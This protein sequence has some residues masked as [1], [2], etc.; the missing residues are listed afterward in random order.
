ME[1]LW[2][3]DDKLFA[4][5]KS[6]SIRLVCLLPLSLLYSTRIILYSNTLLNQILYSINSS[7][8]VANQV[9]L[10]HGSSATVYLATYK[11]GKK[12]VSIKVIDLDMFERNQI[13]ELRV[14][15]LL[16]PL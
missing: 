12:L 10:G 15:Y 16:Y 13:D 14:L 4:I 2:N 5:D 3:T 6:A 8:I 1:Y 9:Y 7:I 11:N